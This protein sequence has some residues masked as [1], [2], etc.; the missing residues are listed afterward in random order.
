MLFEPQSA[1]DLSADHADV[2]IIG[3][4]PLGLMAAL[5]FERAGL[6]VL[7]LES[8]AQGPEAHS[9]DLSRADVRKPQFHTPA[10]INMARRVGGTSHL[11]GGRC[12]P[13]DPIDLEARPGLEVPPWPLS[14]GDVAPYFEEACRFFS[15]GAPVFEAP[16]DG[17]TGPDETFRAT[18]LERWATNPSAMAIHGDHLRTTDRIRI[19]QRVT[20]T[21]LDLEGARV[22]ALRVAVGR[23][24]TPGRLPVGWTVL[25]AGGNESTRLL[26]ATQQDR[27]A[28]FGGPDGPLGRFYM[29][30]ANGQIADIVFE[31]RALEKAFGFYVDEHGSYVRRRFVPSAALQRREGLL[32]V[33]FWPVVPEVRDA[34]HRSGIL[35]SAYLTLSLGPL[36]RQLVAERIRIK[37]VGPP[38]HKRLPHL[39]NVICDLPR[40][41]TFTPWF[42]WHRKIAKRRVPGFFVHN[43]AGRYG[44]E[45]HSE[46][47]P[48]P[49]SRLCLGPDRDRHGLARLAIDY[50]YD[51]RD[52]VSIIKAHE[53]LEQWLRKGDAGHL[54]YRYPKDALED[55]I[56]NEVNHGAHQIG[57]IRM[58]ASS[59]EGVVDADG[60][61]FDLPNLQ[62]LSTAILPTSGQANPTF[63][64][65]AVGLRAID[66][67]LPE[68][69]A[70][71]AGRTP[72]PSAAHVSTG[73]PKI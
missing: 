37:Q 62:V 43:R 59:A 41:A 16:I 34:R 6:R 15:A 73:A 60:R 12:L 25:A 30:H 23:E 63:M 66:R 19:A 22:G 32:N 7:V 35:S 31:D 40:F 11:W 70:P 20:V 5:R 14:H 39:W 10:E 33:S 1:E 44:L 61:S 27:P 58:A 53:L 4:G 21:A 71:A 64:A 68:M 54:D 2:T 26:L 46:Q 69:T 28:L 51:R 56:L 49:N 57:T 50:F 36:G 18:A 42:L 3:A 52:L 9:Q 13:Y 55:G 65:A 45:F 48:N 72:K 38:P 47:W 17:F 8:G 67:V 24:G 29:G